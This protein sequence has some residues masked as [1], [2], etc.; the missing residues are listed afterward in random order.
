MA[1]LLIHYR[2]WAVSQPEKAIL[3]W[4]EGPIR[5]DRR[6]LALKPQ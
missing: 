1:A 2:A 6:L 4:A 5:D 3:Q